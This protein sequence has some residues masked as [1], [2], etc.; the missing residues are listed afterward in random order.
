MAQNLTLFQ[1]QMVLNNSLTKAVPSH[2]NNLMGCDVMVCWF[3][4]IILPNMSLF[5]VELS[6]SKEITC[7]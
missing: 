3:I 2:Q 4:L 7:K 5:S 6:L 1:T